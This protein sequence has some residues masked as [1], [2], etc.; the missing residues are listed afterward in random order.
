[1]MLTVRN[2]QIHKEIYEAVRRQDAKAA[3]CAMSIHI[4]G[5]GRDLLARFDRFQR[6]EHDGDIQTDNFLD[7]LRKNLRTEDGEN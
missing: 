4:R 5:A 2:L 3:R 7:S 1:M 6:R